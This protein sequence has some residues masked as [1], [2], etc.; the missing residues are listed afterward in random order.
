VDFVEFPRARAAARARREVGRGARG[1]GF[2]AG[3]SGLSGAPG[4]ASHKGRSVK[5][6]RPINPARYRQFR[7]LGY[8]PQPRIVGSFFLDFEL[9]PS[10]SASRRGR[11]RFC[12]ERGGSWNLRWVCP[13]GDDSPLAFVAWL[14][15]IPA[16]AVVGPSTPGSLSRIARRRFGQ[17]SEA[18]WGLPPERGPRPAGP[19]GRRFAAGRSGRGRLAPIKAAISSDWLNFQL[20]AGRMNDIH[21]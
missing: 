10:A 13:L 6:L 14:T 16:A 15:A 2:G 21:I 5:H 11:V 3:E 9:R 19:P 8:H 18:R 12:S 17:K 20:T 4:L 1:A 7:H